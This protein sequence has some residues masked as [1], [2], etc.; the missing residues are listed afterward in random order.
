[1]KRL[2]SKPI[3]ILKS[4][5]GKNGAYYE[6]SVR[7]L[8]RHLQYAITC[9]NGYESISIYD[10]DDFEDSF[11]IFCELAMV[12]RGLSYAEQFNKTKKDI[13][14]GLDELYDKEQNML[15]KVKPLFLGDSDFPNV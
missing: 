15:L 4:F 12:L 10:G 1:M 7:I 14:M 2:G 6:Y 11:E 3:K 8:G 5:V 9:L 13:Q